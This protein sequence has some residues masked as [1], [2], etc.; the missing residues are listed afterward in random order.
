MKPKM[1]PHASLRQNRRATIE[2]IF[3]D[4]AIERYTSRAGLAV[5]RSRDVVQVVDLADLVAD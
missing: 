3:H 2:R 4:Q 5:S 1:T